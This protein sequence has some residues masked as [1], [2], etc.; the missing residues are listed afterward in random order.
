MDDTYQPIYDA[1]RSK[2]S[3]F[4]GQDLIDQ[5]SRN[6]DISHHTEIIK[7]EFLNVAFEMQRPSVLF[8]PE[9]QKDGNQWCALLGKDLQVGVAG[10]GDT[11]YQAMGEFDKE[12]EKS[13]KSE[14][15]NAPI[16]VK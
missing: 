13:M 11:P 2:I 3:A 7:Q 14:I 12:W 6:F 9:L 8:K 10:F 16:T 4:N 5:I 1:V 15:K